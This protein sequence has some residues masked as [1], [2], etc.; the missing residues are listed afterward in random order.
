MPEI[1][2]PLTVKQPGGCYWGGKDSVMKIETVEYSKT[3]TGTTPAPRVDKNNVNTWELY[4][5]S[6][7]R[8]LG[9]DI[10]PTPTF[11]AKGTEPAWSKKLLSDYKAWVGK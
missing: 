9:E 7:I 2:V 10:R 3:P 8:L 6:I 1:P 11:A 4:G 5:N